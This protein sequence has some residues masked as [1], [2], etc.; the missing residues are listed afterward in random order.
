MA[1][2]R[3]VSKL[4]EKLID[5]CII[6]PDFVND[7][8]KV[9]TFLNKDVKKYDIALSDEDF[10]TGEKALRAWLNILDK[11]GASQEKLTSYLRVGLAHLCFDYIDLK[12]DKLTDD[13]HIKR[14]L[15]S[16]KKRNYDKSF[17]KSSTK[18]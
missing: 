2:K 7:Y 9:H 15:Q 16:F 18:K 13:D 5:D 3:I 14:A 12:T 8:E 4:D 1:D 10:E 11:K 6:K 17:Y